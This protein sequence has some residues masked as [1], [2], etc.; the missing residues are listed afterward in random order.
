MVLL[1]RH[2]F[3]LSLSIIQLMELVVCHRWPRLNHGPSLSNLTFVSNQIILTVQMHFPTR[4]MC[5]TTPD[6]ASK[7][8][9]FLTVQTHFPGPPHVCDHP[10]CGYQ[11]DKIQQLLRHRTRH[12]DVRPFECPQC[13]K[14]FKT[15]NNLYAHVRIHSG[16]W[17]SFYFFCVPW[18][19]Y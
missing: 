8:K 1:N 6:V 15:Y 16:K 9:T 17:R 2:Y 14:C 10:G 11:D 4:P 7:T 18:V 13:K 3:L 12:S 19:P 5:L